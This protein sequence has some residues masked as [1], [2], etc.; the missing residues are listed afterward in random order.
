MDTTGGNRV[1][2]AIAGLLLVVALLLGV[3]AFEIGQPPR[4]TDA[5]SSA[6]VR[7]LQTEM[8]TLRKD[9]QAN[10]DLLLKVCNL[11]AQSQTA[12]SG[13]SNASTGVD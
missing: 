6:D 8:Q 7:G 12:S 13:S 3:I 4:T 10:T 11:L 5:A 1:S 9:V 2:K